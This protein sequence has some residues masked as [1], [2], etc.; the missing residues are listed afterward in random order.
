VQRSL[1]HQLKVIGS[2]TS[3]TL[4]TLNSEETER[5]SSVEGLVVSSYQENSK[6]A[7]HLPKLAVQSYADSSRC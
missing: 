6:E 7:V 2:P 5:C 3:I 1:L 4:K